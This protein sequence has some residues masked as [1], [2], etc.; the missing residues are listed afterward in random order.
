MKEMINGLRSNGSSGAASLVGPAAEALAVRLTRTD[1]ALG[2][3]VDSPY[4]ED[5]DVEGQVLNGLVGT[6]SVSD[7]SNNN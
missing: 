6:Q 7:E 3:L 4:F 2:A 5:E 1:E